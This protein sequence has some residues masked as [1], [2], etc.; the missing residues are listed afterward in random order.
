MLDVTISLKSCEGTVPKRSI[1]V[2]I[3]FTVTSSP[4]IQPS[5]RAFDTTAASVP[6][7]EFSEE[8]SPPPFA[9]A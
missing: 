7:G 3:T 2:P 1:S 9:V 5:E 6:K 8:P 4:A